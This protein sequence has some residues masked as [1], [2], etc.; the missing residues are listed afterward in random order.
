MWSN[1]SQCVL[2]REG[3]RVFE[4]VSERKEAERERAG[5]SVCVREK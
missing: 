4:K 5:V 1:E 2:G 3:E